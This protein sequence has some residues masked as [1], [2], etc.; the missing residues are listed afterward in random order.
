VLDGKVP[1]PAAIAQ[2]AQ[3]LIDQA[4]EAAIARPVLRLVS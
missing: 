1:V 4:R 3:L 2:Q